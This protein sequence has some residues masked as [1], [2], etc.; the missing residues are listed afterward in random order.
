M[1]RFLYGNKWRYVIFVVFIGFVALFFSQDKFEGQNEILLSVIWGICLCALGFLCV[2][3]RG[4]L[5]WRVVGSRFAPKD[6]V[7][8]LGKDNQK[9]Q[10]VVLKVDKDEDTGVVFAFVKKED[11]EIVVVREKDLE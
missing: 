5:L 10:G 9:T 6:K 2:V 4:Y 7:K 8:I 3:F 1:I 11:G